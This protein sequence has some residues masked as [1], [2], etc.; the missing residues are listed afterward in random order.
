[1]NECLSTI[2]QQDFLLYDFFLKKIFLRVFM[3]RQNVGRN[4]LR[5][6]VKVFKNS[7]EREAINRINRQCLTLIK[8][9]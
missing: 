9:V 3:I 1:M 7:E 5:V 8:N 2:Q 6:K 4:F